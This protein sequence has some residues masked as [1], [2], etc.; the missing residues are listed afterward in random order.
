MTIDN[1]INV[2]NEAAELLARKNGDYGD[3]IFEP[4]IF[5]TPPTFAIKSRI[6]DKI[7]RLKSLFAGR[8]PATAETIDDTEIDLI[9][10]LAFDIA[11]RRAE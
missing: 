9:G 8:V 10:Y 7:R 2:L 3:G 4:D 6:G 5:G 11:L 1:V